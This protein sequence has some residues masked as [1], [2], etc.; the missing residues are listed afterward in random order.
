MG[1]LSIVIPVYNEEGT[2]EKIIDKVNS[3]PIGKEIIIVD[4][5]STDG[6]RNIL[7]KI[8]GKDIK[9]ILNPANLGKGASVRKGIAEA[10]KEFVIIQDA[11]L[12]YDPKDYPALMQP[13]IDN[14][15]DLVLGARFTGGH[16]GMAAHRM[17]NR[18]LTWLINLLFVSK[19]NDYATCYKI[20][21]KSSFIGLGLCASGFDIEVEIVCKALK[22]GLRIAEV[23]ISYYPRS[24]AE[25]KKIRWFDGLDA[26]KSI[27]KY[28]FLKNQGREEA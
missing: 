17:G 10:T 15:A 25:G 4:N 21:R 11:D 8:K 28:K 27:L 14:K 1:E 20:A 2:I 5:F 18:F 19:L 3:V 9:I 6:T 7:S 24:Y 26:I 12:E 16:S 13:L 22:R 23:P